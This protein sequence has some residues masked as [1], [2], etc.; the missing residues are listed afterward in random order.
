VKILG[1]ETSCDETA[2]CIIEAQGGLEKPEFKILGNAL[3]S[4]ISIHAQYGGVF[5]MLAKREHA[6][7]LVPLFKKVL[8]DAGL[9]HLVPSHGLGSTPKLKIILEREYDLY[10]Q[11]LELIQNIEKPDIDAIAV[12]SGPGLEPA[13]WVGINFARA[14]GEAWGIPVIP[15]N[16]M[17]GHIVSV[18]LKENGN[19]IDFPALAL[20]IS[21]GHT[22]LVL[23]KN[24]LEYEVIGNTRDDAVGEAFDKVARLLGLPY[25]GGPQISKLAHDARVA[26]TTPRFTLPRP[27]IKSDD[28]D[29][30]FSGIKTSV[31]YTLK[32]LPEITKEIKLETALE[33][34]NA[35]T[36]VLISKT[37][38]ALEEFNIKTLILGGGVIANTY[39]RQ[40]FEKLIHE[41]PD[42]KLLIPE[43]N[44]ST[45]N[46]VMIAMA[47]YINM[48]AGK[49]QVS[50]SIKAEGNLK[51]N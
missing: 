48:S 4:Q 6:K 19:K 32:K 49:K 2:V 39:I 33:F 10:E 45:D 20:L 31:L 36:E 40:E 26:H 22:E 44:L 18:L 7:N 21:G 14:L 43:I 41:F 17:E 1:I 27:M 8:E 51:L 37:K 42:T 29:F 23:M 13:L 24:W 50:T 35:V 38:K 47:G 30:S 34:E 16:H 9:Y 15:T 25:P 12:T 3:Y 11:T 5:P 46:A 28:Y